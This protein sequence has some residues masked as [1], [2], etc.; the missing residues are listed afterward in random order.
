M[1]K[2]IYLIIVLALVASWSGCK[3]WKKPTTADIT[4]VCTPL[5][6]KTVDV[7]DLKAELHANATYESL[8]YHFAVKG[9]AT[10]STGT[11]KEITPGK[12]FLVVWKDLD[13]SG[14]FS[15]ND[16]FGFYPTALNLVAGDVKNLTVEMYIVE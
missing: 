3:K 14:D 7:S 16:I 13:S 1:K 5:A 6:G 4:V 15:K 2:I 9:T 11:L 8:K 10:S 12:Y